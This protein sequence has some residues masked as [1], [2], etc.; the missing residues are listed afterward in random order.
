MP[1][2]DFSRLTDVDVLA[3]IETRGGAAYSGSVETGLCNRAPYANAQ[4]RR[5]A[6]ERALASGAVVRTPLGLLRPRPR[7]GE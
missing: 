1:L 3:V 7:D 6:I 5:R 2:P 4:D